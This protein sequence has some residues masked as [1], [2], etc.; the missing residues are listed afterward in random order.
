[1]E[2]PTWDQFQGMKVSPVNQAS[3]RWEGS[4]RADR[5]L[6]EQL[7]ARVE[8]LA[9]GTPDQKLAELGGL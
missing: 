9:I 1:M 2:A 4:V 5:V 7:V 8:G 3:R 6:L